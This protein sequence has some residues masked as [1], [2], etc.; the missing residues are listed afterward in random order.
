MPSDRNA[1]REELDGVSGDDSEEQIWALIDPFRHADNWK[2][3]SAYMDGGVDVD[4][5]FVR[6][7]RA[8]PN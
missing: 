6:L 4:G 3:S 8:A 1:R 5:L 2:K 7:A